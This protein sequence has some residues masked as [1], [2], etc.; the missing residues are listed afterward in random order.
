MRRDEQERQPCLEG[1]QERRSRFGDLS[2]GQLGAADARVPGMTR[3]LGNIDMG[4][5]GIANR[6]RNDD[7]QRQEGKHD[8]GSAA[9]RFRA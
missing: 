3:A 8:E 6:R 1:R 7:R 9:H 5:E 4:V 2:I